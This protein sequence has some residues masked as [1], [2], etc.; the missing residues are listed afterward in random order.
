MFN[1]TQGK[2]S[3]SDY[4]IELRTLAAESNWNAPA[5]FDTFY[6]GLSDRIKDKLASRDLPVDLDAL[7]ALALY[8]NGCLQERKREKFA[9]APGFSPEPVSGTSGDFPEPMQLGQTRL[10]TEERQRRLRENKFM[11]CASTHPLHVLPRGCW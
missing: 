6:N 9:H 7:V 4:S 1:L 11:Y 2:R 5:L 10:S 8:I 3:V